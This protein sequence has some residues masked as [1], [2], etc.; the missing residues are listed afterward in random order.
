MPEA[1]STMASSEYQEFEHESLQDRR[2]IVEYLAALGEGFRQ[3]KLSLSRN[4]E[5]VVLATPDLLRFDVQAKQKRDRAQ[6]VVKMSWKTDTTGKKL[7]VEP[8]EIEA[9]QTEREAQ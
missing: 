8:L 5:T 4:G 7:R 6:L 3:G 9:S 1:I 2:S